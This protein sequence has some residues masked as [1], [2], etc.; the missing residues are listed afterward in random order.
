M[1]MKNHCNIMPIDAVVTILSKP[2]MV[3]VRACEFWYKT[4]RYQSIL[5]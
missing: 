5:I 1:L 2:A 3:W 4:K